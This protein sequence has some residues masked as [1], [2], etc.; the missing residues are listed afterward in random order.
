M[1]R[2]LGYDVLWMTENNPTLPD[3]EII[4]LA[5]ESERIIITGDKDFGE[6]IFR[7]QLAVT[8]IVL[9]R[10]KGHDV[11]EKIRLMKILLTVY[12]SRL[13]Y[14]FIVATPTKLRFINLAVNKG[15]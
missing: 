8:G 6:L 15:E 5:I 1:I 7:H 10:V 13:Q 11:R 4:A 12:S 2:Q 3:D 14:H 9:L